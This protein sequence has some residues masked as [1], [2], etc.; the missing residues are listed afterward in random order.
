MPTAVLLNRPDNRWQFWCA[1]AG[2]V[3]IHLA[4]VGV[5][6]ITPTGIP[7]TITISS[8]FHDVDIVDISEPHASDSMQAPLAEATTPD[9]EPAAPE[10][11]ELP[12]AESTPIAES[13]IPGKEATPPPVRRSAP[14]PPQRLVRPTTGTPGGATMAKS[15]RSLAI[16]AP[17]P[18]YPHEAR[19]CHVTGSGVAM[20]TVDFAGRVVRVT[21][22]RSTGSG[23]LDGATISG[24]KRWRFRPG[25]PSKVQT[26]ITFMLTGAS[27]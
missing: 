13:A 14:K 24:L 23:V 20:L 21:M 18:E 12:P 1:L 2:A 3:L 4:A 27:S 15:A 22:V 25:T 6:A 5:A 10:E 17:P 19:R 7:D 9:P 26:P 11:E 8:G 16:S